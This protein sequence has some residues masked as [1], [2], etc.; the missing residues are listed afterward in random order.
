MQRASLKDS[1]PIDVVPLSLATSL[2]PRCLRVLKLTLADSIL[3]C[4]LHKNP[5]QQPCRRT[6]TQNEKL[7]L[8]QCFPGAPPHGVPPQVL[9][10][11]FVLR[12]L[13]QALAIAWPSCPCVYPA[14]L[15]AGPV[16]APHLY[17]PRSLGAAG[18]GTGRGGSEAGLSSPAR[19]ASPSQAEPP[20]PAP[21][22][23][24]PCSRRGRSDLQQ[25]RGA[26][27]DPLGAAPPGAS[28]GGGRRVARSPEPLGSTR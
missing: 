10:W 4:D 8:P 3:C 18:A 19:A 23:S 9:C 27:L 6:P 1:L 25:S 2:D 26:G 14:A 20:S 28:D 5:R 12:A 7:G 24:L 21:S 11:P 22:V 15:R 16:A 17:A 13:R